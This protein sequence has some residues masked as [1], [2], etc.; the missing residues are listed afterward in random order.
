MRTSMVRP[1]DDFGKDYG[2]IHE[3]VVTGRKAG[4]GKEFWAKLA[5]DSTLFENL[6]TFVRG[7]EFVET[8]HSRAL[9]IMGSNFFGIAQAVQ[10]LKVI[11]SPQ[12]LDDLSRIP[13]S[14]RTLEESRDTHV[15]LAV[16]PLSINQIR[17]RVAANHGNFFSDSDWYQDQPFA[18]E[19]GKTGW[20]LVRKSPVPNSIGAT[21]WEERL[22]LLGKNE[23][24]PKARIVV[25][26]MTGYYLVTGDSLFRNV[27]VYCAD[28]KIPSGHVDIGGVN[29]AKI[30]GS[31]HR[32]L[33][34][35]RKPE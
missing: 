27:R 20:Q 15:L 19:R 13:F 18:T 28:G 30:G 4:A 12:E 11:P 22:A 23:E 26:M 8:T 29:P 35:A 14:E 5:H 3:A 25:Y 24:V 31:G 6:V 21:T 34:S 17:N 1:D 16:F 7:A 9:A 2:L 10:H 33:A 32:G